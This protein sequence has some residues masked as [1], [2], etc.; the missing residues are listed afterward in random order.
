MPTEHT[1]LQDAGNLLNQEIKKIWAEQGHTLTGAW[2]DSLSTTSY[3]PNEI[4]GWAKSYGAIVN[5]GVTA[6]R[7]PFG[8]TGAGGTSQYIQGL[9]RF[10]KLRKPGLTD[11]EA[12]SLAFATA[13]KQKQEGMSTVASGVF[14]QWGDRQ[15]FI[16][17]AL[18]QKDEELAD[19]VCGGLAQV[20]NE[21]IGEPNLIEY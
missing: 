2:E 3:A 11:K 20:V 9:F 15:H 17:I 10:W 7:I 6:S 1:I 16:E 19:F 4:E 13:K 18:I 14:S 12:L 5:A 21:D 8:E